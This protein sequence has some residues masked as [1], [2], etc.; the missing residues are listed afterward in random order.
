MIIISMPNQNY[1]EYP[2]SKENLE[3]VGEGPINASLYALVDEMG[4]IKPEEQG[5]YD[6]G[7]FNNM[8][9]GRTELHLYFDGTSDADFYD[10]DGSHLGTVISSNTAGYEEEAP[11]GAF[12]QSYESDKLKFNSDDS[13]VYVHNL[14]PTQIKSILTMLTPE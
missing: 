12:I 2:L 7:N 5:G 9:G 13:M 1:R 8:S 10:K 3:T 4:L 11:Q 6:S 14:R